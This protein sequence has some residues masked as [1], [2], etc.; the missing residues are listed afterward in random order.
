MCPS[1]PGV[2]SPDETFNIYYAERSIWHVEFT[3]P[4]QPGHG[5]LLLKNTAGEKVRN[6]LDRFID[7]RNTQVKRLEND[8]ELTIGDVTTLNL[9]MMNGGVQSNVIPPEFK[10]TV[11]I[12]LALDID[13]QEYENMFKE[14]CEQSGEGITYNFHQKMPK[15]Q[16]TIIDKTSPFWMCFKEAIDEL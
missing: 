6:L 8:P 11:D 16:P 9:T 15:V 14:W 10:V 7:Y 3:V 2:A 4:G 13:H 12:R 5:S 1:R